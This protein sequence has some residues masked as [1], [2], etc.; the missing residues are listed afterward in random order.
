[1]PRS[2]RLNVGAGG[3]GSEQ[4]PLRTE[5]LDRAGASAAVNGKANGLV[6]RG[7]CNGPR[8]AGRGNV[9]EIDLAPGRSAAPSASPR[10]C[11]F[12]AQ[13]RGGRKEW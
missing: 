7:E 6:F 8:L 2:L 4:K 12:Y 10:R 3:S 5:S 1:M 9:G 11:Y 13:Q